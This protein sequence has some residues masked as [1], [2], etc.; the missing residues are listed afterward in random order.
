[1]F[2]SS[3]N[4]RICKPM[5]THAH[6]HTH[7]H[8]HKH[9][10]THT[11][12]HTYTHTHTHTHKHKQVH[13]ATNVLTNELIAIKRISKLRCVCVCVCVCLCVC[14]CVYVCACVCVC[15]SVC[16]CVCLCLFVY[17]CVRVCLCVCTCEYYDNAA[18]KSIIFDT[19]YYCFSCLYRVLLPRKKKVTQMLFSFLFV[20]FILAKSILSASTNDF[21]SVASCYKGC[22]VSLGSLSSKTITTGEEHRIV[23]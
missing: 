11:N 4:S 10:H 5:H 12:L 6:T 23:G 2:F 1:M 8:T 20:Y 9:T 19:S 16:V 21:C 7:T 13:I 22:F 14:V 3:T 15:L 18:Q 17:V